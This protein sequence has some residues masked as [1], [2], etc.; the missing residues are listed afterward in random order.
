MVEAA[1]KWPQ[2]DG[3]GYDDSIRI[4]RSADIVDRYISLILLSMHLYMI[5]VTSIPA[6]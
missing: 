4:D 5:A 1:P 2:R 3:R 6:S